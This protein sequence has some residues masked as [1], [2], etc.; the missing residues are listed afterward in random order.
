MADD[1]IKVPQDS[2]Y[3]VLSDTV[4]FPHILASIAFHDPRAMAAIDDA[5]N[6]DPKTLVCV[7]GKKEEDESTHPEII[8]PEQAIEIFGDGPPV[9]PGPESPEHYA[10]GTLVVIHKLL[11]IPAGGI[12]IMVQGV[13]RVR[14]EED[15]PGFSFSRARISEIP[16]LPEKTDTT[17]ALLRTILSQAKKLGTLAS[18]LPDEF[19]T[20]TLN[21]E[22]PYHLSYLIATFLR[23]PVGDRQGVLEAGRLEEKLTL[24]ARH[25]VREIEIQE[26]GGKIKSKIADEV[27][28]SQRDFFLREQVKAIQ[29]ELG[30][31]EEGD[32]DVVRY[33]KKAQE[34]GLSP[35]AEKEVSR[36][37]S[38]LVRAGNQSQ[39]GQVIRT[40]LDVVLDLPWNRESPE[41]YDLIEARRILDVDHYDLEK[42]KERILDELAVLARKKKN[43]EVGRGPILCLIGPPGVG[44]TTLGQSIAR[45]MGREFVRISLGGVRDEAEIRGHRRTYVGAMPG[46]I[47]AGLRKAQTKNPVFMLDEIDKVGADYRG[48]PSSALLEVL[49]TAQNKDFRDHY[50][51]LAFDLSRVFFIT[52]A[53]VAQTIPAPLL[54]RMDLIPLSGY[55]WEEKL[56]IARSYLIPRAMG[57]L[58]LSSREFTLPDATLK[59]IIREFTREAGVRS[60]GRKITTILR[61][62]VRSRALQ[63]R[64]KKIV[65]RGIDL[66]H[67]LGNEYIE[68]ETRLRKSGPGLV[69]GLAWTP[70]GGEVLFV[71]SVAIP[72]S[73]GFILTGQLGD[74]MKES[75]RT[76]LSFAQSRCRMLGISPE[77]FAKNEIHIH[78]PGG[79]IP[80]DGPSAGIT[81]T[82]TILSLA[83]R[84]P[85]PSTVAMTGEISLSGRVLPVGG[86][87]EKLIG[88][89]E[90]GITTVYLPEKNLKD[91][92]EL[93]EEVRRDLDIRPVESMDQLIGIF[94]GEAVDEAKKGRAKSSP[95]NGALSRA[96]RRE[97]R[98]RRGLTPP[99]PL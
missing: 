73:K 30:D 6:R 11:R 9:Q 17:E 49:D 7:A 91:T 62:V 13:R 55:T 48:D 24:V 86:I 72:G 82:T 15:I 68:P 39:E 10:V 66:T 71:E 83:T 16:E 46:R 65:V 4:V 38:R 19:E 29:K 33:R 37:I 8:S 69:T 89:R 57:E 40:Y 42:V 5:M 32:E 81:M 35:E 23:L 51:D 67:Y 25:L 78:V 50:L 88:A 54:D 53:N 47:I 98:E 41:S 22:N 84:I 74:V 94:F 45:S 27:Q 59:K 90:A 64:K 28:K 79:A 26:L 85:V 80:K 92:S 12:A 52:T 97:S 95:G 61:K 1:P 36:E 21:V 34:A 2:P 60:L 76:A 56:H 93:P 43:D 87:K 3:V 96:I 99:P 63:E 58:S 77:F 18:Y 44:K 31:G 14:L 20:M 70:N 75:A